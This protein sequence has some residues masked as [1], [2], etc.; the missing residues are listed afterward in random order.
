M[1]SFNLKQ[2]QFTVLSLPSFNF[3]HLQRKERS[4]RWQNGLEKP[5]VMFNSKANEKKNNVT[6]HVFV[7]KIILISLGIWKTREKLMTDLV[8]CCCISIKLSNSKVDNFFLSLFESY[9]ITS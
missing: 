7:A 8:A 6:Y 9:A 2:Q 4:E 5:R 1:K 3:A